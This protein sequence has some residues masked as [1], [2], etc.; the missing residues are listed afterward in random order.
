MKKLLIP[1]FIALVLS[2]NVF[3]GSGYVSV[4]IQSIAAVGAN[5]FGHKTGNMEIRIKNGFTPPLGVICDRNYITTLKTADPDRATLSLLRDAYNSGRTVTLG[6][7]DS[8]TY[9]AYPGRCSILSIT[10]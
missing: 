2:Q 7:T 8:P 10:E 9:T 5:A 3:A 6:I 4:Q 1:T